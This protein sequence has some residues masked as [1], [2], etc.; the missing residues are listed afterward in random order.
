M[1][2]EMQRVEGVAKDPYTAQLEAKVAELYGALVWCSGGVD[3][4]PGGMARESW[5]RIVEPLLA[6][7]VLRELPLVSPGAGVIAT[8]RRR[9]IEVEGWTA[10]HDNNHRDGELTRAAAVYAVDGDLFI[11]ETRMVLVNRGR[12]WAD[13]DDYAPVTDL[14]PLWPWSSAWYK[15]KD[16]LRDLIRAGALIAAE[17]DR[18][19]AQ[20]PNTNT[21]ENA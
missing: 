6:A 5:E 1:P 15:P 19:L 21:K 17:I 16:R 4:M 8:E 2:D 20:S 9:Q 7:P 12:P 18:L 3:Y 13:P 11:R 10:E 14:Y